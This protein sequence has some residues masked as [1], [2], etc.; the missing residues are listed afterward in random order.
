MCVCVCVCLCVCVCVCYFQQLEAKFG[1]SQKE[2]QAI[3]AS[4][5]NRLEGPRNSID[6]FVVCNLLI[7]SVLVLPLAD[8]DV[9]VWGC[10][11]VCACVCMKMYLCVSLCISCFFNQNALNV[12]T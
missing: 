11:C 6:Q 2:V 9:R 5:K 8:V 1:Y 7:T 4:I 10:V 3:S 12:C